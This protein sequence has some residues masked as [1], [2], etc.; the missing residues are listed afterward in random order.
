MMTKT[1]QNKALEERILNLISTQRYRETA[2]SLAAKTKMSVKAVKQILYSL[3]EQ[4]HVTARRNDRQGNRIFE[5]KR[6][7]PPLTEPQDI[8]KKFVIVPPRKKD[9]HLL[10]RG[11]NLIMVHSVLMRSEPFTM[12][13]RTIN[14]K[15]P[16]KLKNVSAQLNTLRER[17][18]ASCKVDENTGLLLWRGHPEES[19]L[20]P[21]QKAFYKHTRPVVVT[22]KEET[23]TETE[24]E[25]EID[26]TLSL[27]D[28]LSELTD[29]VL[30]DLIELNEIAGA[31][32][33][34]YD[35]EQEDKLARIN[36]ILNE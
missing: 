9:D 27:H 1:E 28:R 30:S 15:L 5:Y 11:T 19:P 24:T 36:A 7:I 33:E 2:M 26:A 14:A 13:S 31:L 6:H 35:N 12:N 32:K 25:K 29:R 8:G 20:T 17:G 34:Q 10:R 21:P 22:K 4:G 18:L 23:E 16:K 3:R